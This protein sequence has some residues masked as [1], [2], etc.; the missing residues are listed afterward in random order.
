MKHKKTA[1]A[2]AGS[3]I[4]LGAAV[5]AFASE[6]ATGPN[7]SANGGLEQ[8]LQSDLLAQPPVDVNGP[9]VDG[10][11][12]AVK[13]TTKNGELSSDKNLLGADK[14]EQLLGGLPLGL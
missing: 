12:D 1:A 3:M 13:G 4:A 11:V 14:A 8:A 7:F 2:V 9:Q 6:T 10:L 5:P